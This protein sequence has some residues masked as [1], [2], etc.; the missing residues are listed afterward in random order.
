MI[1]QRTETTRTGTELTL[2]YRDGV[3]FKVSAKF[4]EAKAA[5]DFR[6]NHW[7][8]RYGKI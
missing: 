7:T 1:E 3:L 4:D 6:K 2:H 5:A 8:G